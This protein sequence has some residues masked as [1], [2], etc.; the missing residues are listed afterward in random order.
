[1]AVVSEIEDSELD[2]N[3]PKKCVW[4]KAVHKLNGN[5]LHGLILISFRRNINLI[6]CN[7]SEPYHAPHVPVQDYKNR[8]Y[9]FQMIWYKTYPWIHYDPIL[10]R[11]VCFTCKSATSKGLFPSD[12]KIEETFTKIGYCNWK[13]GHEGFRKHESCSVHKEAVTK[14]LTH[15]ESPLPKQL[16]SA[17]LKKQ[18]EARKALKVI[19]TT[20]MFLAKQ[21]LAL[22]GDDSSSGNF[23]SLLRLRAADVTE[24]SSWLR[25]TK[26]YTSGQIQNEILET[27]SYSILRNIAAKIHSAE[28]Y[29]VIVD[30]TSDCSNKEQVS[31]SVRI[32]TNDLEVD[33]LF[34][35]L[36]DPPST[37]GEILTNVIL[38][39]LQRF[40]LPLDK[41]R[42]QCYDG[43]ANMSGQFK[44]VQSRILDRQPK[45]L[46]VHCFNHGLNLALQDTISKNNFFRDILSIVHE[47]GT[48]IHGSPKRMGRFEDIMVSK[49]TES[50]VKPRP[51]CTTRWTVRE[52]SIDGVLNNY[53]AVLEF[54]EE[55]SS[56]NDSIAS[57][58]GGLQTQ[59]EKGEFY[60]G[61]VLAKKMFHI[62]ESLSKV[63]QKKTETISGAIEA[64][65]VTMISLRDLKSEEKFDSAWAEIL[66][67][68]SEYSLQEP[69]L[70]RVRR[71]PK[72]LDN[73]SN[74]PV[75][76]NP[77][78]W[79]K[80][81]FFEGIEFMIKEIKR[82]FDQPGLKL[83]EQMEN[84][85]IKSSP[86]NKVDL[87]QICQFYD[88]DPNLLASE[89]SVLRNFKDTQ[90]STTND[91]VTG[92][93]CLKPESRLLLPTLKDYLKHLL[94]IPCSSAGAERSFSRLRRIKSY[95]RNSMGQSRL[96]HCCV[97]NC[98]ADLVDELDVND[99]LQKFSNERGRGATFGSQ[100]FELK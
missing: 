59:L 70:P 69:S 42:G 75:F 30:E 2:A 20:T 19:F 1:L 43:A 96:N 46:Y 79:L 23:M 54:L 78:E 72:K 55:L 17:T 47:T 84:A 48:A 83:Y 33:E 12:F 61:L 94:V 29:S 89:I 6:K 8:T 91:I 24:I 80:S 100:A 67:K 64:A 16:C 14:L 81:T 49:Q 52:K 76:N 57:K 66:G 71:K 26:T 98:Y 7:F 18:E 90:W 38:D 58:A 65:K 10:K 36:Y 45:A 21:G 41:L 77:K 44:G 31:I 35:G 22:R 74:P 27:V 37:T 5:E 95:L 40:D 25:R 68:I 50:S 87:E 4:C 11:V 60:V 93:K 28:F 15:N 39:V 3:A 62:G 63:L 97:I 88:W 53:A 82:R 34:L 86:A 99:L 51:L 9:K 13:N 85:L 92:F 73:L 56:S 32:A